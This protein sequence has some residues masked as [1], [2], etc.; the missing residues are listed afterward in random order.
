MSDVRGAVA[1]ID[2]NLPVAELNTLEERIS[3]SVA[4]PRV[5]SLL[6]SCLAG[7][8]TVLAVVGIF[9]VLAYA[10]AQ[11]TNEIGIRMALGAD[12]GDVVC[13]V[14]R[15]GLALLMLG[16]TIGLLVSLLTVHALEGFLF[17]VN[18]VD[19][20]TLLAVTALLAQ[21]SAEKVGLFQ[22]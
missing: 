1:S 14:L 22:S 8:A 18:P 12:A 17:E 11:R 16:L 21:S 9:G 20:A 3:E 6:M 5:R 13:S 7:V 15:R 10:V 2:P 4:G 19:P